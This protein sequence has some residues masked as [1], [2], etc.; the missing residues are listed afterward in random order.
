MNKRSAS[1]PF[2]IAGAGIAGLSAAIALSLEGFK[3]VLLE[4]EPALK[5]AGT[6]IQLG[7]NATRI[8]N[9]WGVELNRACAPDWLAFRSMTSGKTLNIMPLGATAQQRYG[10]SY[11]TLLRAD[12][13]AA[14]L[15]RALSLGVDIRF[16]E[17]L[18]V[19][20]EG[21]GSITVTASGCYRGAA[22]IA[23]DGIHSGIRAQL[24]PESTPVFQHM[25]AWRA[26]L[27]DIAFLGMENKIGLWLGAGAHLVHYPVSAEAA[28]N[29]VLIIED[30][31]T[32]LPGDYPFRTRFSGCAASLRKLLNAG[33]CWQPWPLYTAPPLKRWSKGKTLLIGDAA[34]A[35]LPFLASGAVMAIEDAAALA[36]ALTTS[37]GS[38][39]AAFARFEAERRP[40]IAR[41]AYRSGLM[42]RI[43]HMHAPGAYMRNAVI[44]GIAPLRL[45]GQNDW[46]YGYRVPLQ[47]G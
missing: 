3:A 35:M 14:L 21:Q 19:I 38:V 39:A 20:E 5:A 4:R 9:A 13:H 23:A 30:D 12:L 15:R 26:M 10:A 2:I 44:A 17:E 28:H 41:A 11:F 43:Y 7:P 40:R 27:P 45:L 25:I 6:G 37:A 18:K 46:L 34:H 16:G 42:G 22:L 32:S 8:L 36:S 31:G 29:A 33:D 47:R 1:S 24:F